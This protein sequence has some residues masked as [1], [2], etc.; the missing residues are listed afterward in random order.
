MLSVMIRISVFLAVI[1]LILAD[2]TEPLCSGLKS[3]AWSLWDGFSSDCDPTD[4]KRNAITWYICFC[5]RKLDILVSYRSLIGR[6]KNMLKT[7]W[8]T[9]NKSNLKTIKAFFFNYDPNLSHTTSV[10]GIVV[11][12]KIC[13]LL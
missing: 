9:V 10:V 13:Y 6:K 1:H 4:L 2:S 12:I 7:R 5:C 11:C 3:T 8:I